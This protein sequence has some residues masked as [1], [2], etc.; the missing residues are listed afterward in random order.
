MLNEFKPCIICKESKLRTDFHKN[1]NKDG[2]FN[3]CKKCH[4][5]RNQIRRKDTK[6]KEKFA[7]YG[8]FNALFRRYGITR[9]QWYEFLKKQNNQCIICDTIPDPKAPHKQRTLHV[10]HCHKTGKIRGLLCQLCNRGIG[11]FRDRID[12]IEK[13]IIYLKSHD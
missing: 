6:N 5:I 4:Y 3:V 13:A 12:L 11:L 7:E 10:D 8:K 1:L 9:E 2:R